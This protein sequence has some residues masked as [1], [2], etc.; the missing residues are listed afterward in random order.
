MAGKLAY[1]LA[2]SIEEAGSVVVVVELDDALDDHVGMEDHELLRE[3][4]GDL[5]V[6]GAD[7]LAGLEEDGVGLLEVA[8]LLLLRRYRDSDLRG[9]LEVAELAVQLVG[10]LGILGY[11]VDFA[12]QVVQQ[13]LNQV[14]LK[15]S[16]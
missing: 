16:P 6:V 9:R 12:H 10:P 1:V 11:I 8:V 15:R 14:V 7:V 5:Q 2:H 3:V 13:A 4:V